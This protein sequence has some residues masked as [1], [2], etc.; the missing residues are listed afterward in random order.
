MNS[1]GKA[2]FCLAHSVMAFR[3]RGITTSSIRAFLDMLPVGGPCDDR[4][5]AEVLAPAGLVGDLALGLAT[6]LA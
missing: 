3:S 1:I 4:T 2:G 5:V 6:D